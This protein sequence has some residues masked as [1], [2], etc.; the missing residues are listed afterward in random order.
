MHARGEASISR[1]G[2]QGVK[3]GWQ[4]QTVHRAEMRYLR[5]ILDPFHLLTG[6]SPVGATSGGGVPI[7][8]GVRLSALQ[9]WES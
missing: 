7:D 3:S 1:S 5:L 2:Y 8:G 6:R 4:Q 9:C